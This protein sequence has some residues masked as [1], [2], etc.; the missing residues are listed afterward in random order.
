[1]LADTDISYK[2]PTCEM[3]FFRGRFGMIAS[4][5]VVFAVISKDQCL[6]IDK[7]SGSE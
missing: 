6:S 1:M 3:F 7:I 5:S 4:I 2:F